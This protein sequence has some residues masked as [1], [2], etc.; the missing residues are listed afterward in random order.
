MSARLEM[1]ASCSCAVP[2]TVAENGER[3]SGTSPKPATRALFPALLPVMVMV[4]VGGAAGEAPSATASPATPPA[5]S[6]AGTAGAGGE[7]CA[8]ALPQARAAA[9]MEASVG[10]FIVLAIRAQGTQVGKH[11]ARARH[12]RIAMLPCARITS[13]R[14]KGTVSVGTGRFPGRGQHP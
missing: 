14:F 8:N 7:G 10:F 12:V 1:P 13:I 11:G 3:D 4:C 2:T 6:T 9:A 5:L